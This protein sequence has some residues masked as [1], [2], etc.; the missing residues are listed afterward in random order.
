MMPT[1]NRQVGIIFLIYAGIK[2]LS[3]CTTGEISVKKKSDQVDINEFR[4]QIEVQESAHF[5]MQVEMQRLVQ[6]LEVHQIE[7]VS[8]NE[9]LKQAHVELTSS[10]ER[11][12]DFYDYAPV[13]YFI[14]ERNGAIREANLTGASLLG[15]E[16]LQ[17]PTRLFSRFICADSRP[18]FNKFLEKVFRSQAKE[19]C[20]VTL[21]NQGREPLYVHIEAKVSGDK[22]ECRIAVMDVTASKYAE[23]E[24]KA[25]ISTSLDGFLITDIHGRILAVNDAY[26]RLIGYSGDVLKTMHIQDV[27][28]QESPE[29]TTQ[30][31][32]TIIRIGYDRFTTQH[33]CKNG[34]IA[35]MEVS[36]S[37]VPVQGGRFIMFLNDITTQKQVE[38]RLKQSEHEKDVILSTMAEKVVYHD[39][40]MKIRWANRAACDF[41]G[42]LPEEVTGKSC[43]EI[44]DRRGEDCDECPVKKVMQ[45]GHY[46]QDTLSYPDG[47][48][49][50]ISAHPVSDADGGLTGV[51]EVSLDITERVKMETELTKAKEECAAANAAKS[52][53][54]SYISHEMRT[55]MSVIIG[56]AHLVYDSVNGQEEKENID[57]IRE[58]AAF[59][60]T[61]INRILDLSKI[62]AGM[63]ELAQVPFHLPREVERT[64]SSLALQAENSGLE[65]TCSIDDNVPEIVI[66]DPIRLQQVLVNLIGNAIKFTTAG[67]VAINIRQ[68]VAGVHFSITDTGIGIPLDQV[69]RLFHVFSQID[70]FGV[71]KYEGTGLGLAISKN[72]VELMGG[73]IGVKSVENRGSTFYFTIPFALPTGVGGRTETLVPPKPW[74]GMLEQPLWGAKKVL[75]ILIV[76][77]KPM[78]Q[79]LATVLLEKEG[80][81]IIT[82]INGKEALEKLKVNVFDLIIMDIHMP[83]MDGLEATARIRASEDEVVSSI[84]IIAMTACVMKEDRDMCLRAGMDYYIPK[85]ID[86]GELYYTLGKAMEGRVSV[87]EQYALPLEEVHEMLNRV[88][89]NRKLLGELVDMFIEDYYEDIIKLKNSMDKKDAPALAIVVHGLKGELGNLGFTTAYKLVCKLEKNIKKAIPVMDLT[90]LRQLEKQVKGLERFFSHPGWQ[91]RI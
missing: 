8:Q 73:T 5:A 55:P 26:C 81:K 59:L 85:P 4:R 19:T 88:D 49:L 64:V 37:F 48:T 50:L 3:R 20:V 53:F 34:R 86:P 33:R 24:Y 29:E 32:D 22:R 36:I 7:L 15:E 78:N 66:G 17:L 51:V 46:S 42:V 69:D 62:E 40:E 14:L 1:A 89:G 43:Y 75:K 25:I 13:G 58:S 70:T 18:T 38:A 71:R 82:A 77:D 80:H 21:K 9:E 74:E 44:L 23:E 39:K 65:L 79:K 27:V 63:L 2:S 30:L 47:K 31:F 91:E 6:E 52:S 68:D 41:F 57:M 61:L 67:C 10:L 90:T 84:P 83:E 12:T 54:L 72:L 35:D 60:L 28:A 56:M 45:T 11:Y 16:R 76:E 87:L